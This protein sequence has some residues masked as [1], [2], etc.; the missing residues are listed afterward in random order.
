MFGFRKKE[1]VGIDIGS[2]S[3]KLVQLKEVKGGYELVK[4]GMA[5]LPT[6]AVMDNTLMDIPAIVE[7]VRSLSKSLGVK[8]RQVACSLS[9]N[10]VIIR[11]LSF[12]TMTA[13]ELEEQIHWEAEQY[14]PFDINDVNIDFHILGPDEVDP[15]KMN[16]ILVASKKE[17]IST[18]VA[19]FKEAG[20]TLTVLDVDAFAL[21]NAFEANYDSSPDEIIALADMGDATIN[22]NIVR[23]GESLFTRD[24]QMGGNLYTL[25]LQRK[26]GI[27]FEEAETLKLSGSGTGDERT[28]GVILQCNETLAMELYRSMNFYGA[29][30]GAERISKLYVSG[31]C[32]RTPFLLDAIRN[33]LEIPVEL[34]DPFQKIIFQEKLFDSG[35]LKEAAPH[36]AVAVGLAMRR[37]GDK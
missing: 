5:P 10:A 1:L 14:I 28:M 37:Y 33:R 15:K 36:V 7:V 16:V 21:Q 29:N 26:L 30:A 35:Y 32:S 22:L 31:G 23:Q 34:I 4:I 17:I 3:I 19:L 24:I 25:E 2:T 12:P 18:Y 9:G 6:Q 27:T 13:Q 8:V 11:Q 20:M